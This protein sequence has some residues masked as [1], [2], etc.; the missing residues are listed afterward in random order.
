MTCKKCESTNVTIQS[1]QTIKTKHRG[2]I[3][4]TLWLLLAVCT[5]GLIIIIPL[6]TNSKVKTKNKQV[7]ICQDCGYKWN[8]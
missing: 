8:V 4:W 1:E 2:I 3:G 5:G 7:A 6:L